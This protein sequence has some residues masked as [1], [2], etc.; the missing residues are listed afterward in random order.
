VELLA[1]IPTDPNEGRAGFVALVR[2]VLTAVTSTNFD[3]AQVRELLSFLDLDEP[4]ISDLMTQLERYFQGESLE[5]I[6]T[7]VSCLANQSYL[8]LTGT[9]AVGGLLYDLMTIDG[10][11]L[12]ELLTVMAP[13]LEQLKDPELQTISSAIVD[14]FVEDL[15]LRDLAIDLL[16]FLLR[17]DNLVPVLESI[18]V[19]LS[20]RGLDD[21]LLVMEGL[22]VRCSES[23]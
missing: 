5:N 16:V 13:I 3:F 8:G 20:T 21:I 11:E 23:Q 14:A 9:D 4:P 15:E 17:E 22:T 7:T 19:M 2:A 18:E 6:R 10:L 1:N 12:G